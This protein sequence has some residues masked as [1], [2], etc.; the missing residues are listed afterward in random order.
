MNATKVMRRA[1]ALQQGSD[2]RRNLCE[3]L[4]HREA[5]IEELK[6]L[7]RGLWSDMCAISP[8]MGAAWLNHRLLN[9]IVM[10]ESEDR[11]EDWH[12]AVSYGIHA[13]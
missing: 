9:D 4:A 10:E 8:E 3:I 6:H 5:D 13:D 7:A 2:N 1:D 11:H 12:S